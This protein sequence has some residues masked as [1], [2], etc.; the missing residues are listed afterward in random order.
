S[1]ACRYSG[2]TPH[3]SRRSRPSSPSSC[4][5]GFDDRRARA[6]GLAGPRAR[7]G[8]RRPRR[9]RRPRRAAARARLRGDAAP[10]AAATVAARPALVFSGRSAWVTEGER[11][12]RGTTVAV[13][14]AHRVVAVTP[15]T[16][17]VV[18]QDGGRRVVRDWRLAAGDAISLR[19]GDTL[20]A[21]AGSRLRF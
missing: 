4:R 6:R 9:R 14:E 10:G 5:V 13:D 8:H 21:A 18:E 17:R 2:G 15:G 7:G 11:F 20:T 19:P 3:S 12:V 16:F 1:P